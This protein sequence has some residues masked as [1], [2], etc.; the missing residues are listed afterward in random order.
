M[1][2]SSRLSLL[3]IRWR[4]LWL[5]LSIALVALA[6]PGLGKLNFESDTRIVGETEALTVALSW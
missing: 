2:F 6:S 4:Y 3:I 5:C 1:T